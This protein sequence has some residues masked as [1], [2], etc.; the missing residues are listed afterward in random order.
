MCLC[1]LAEEFLL[2]KTCAEFVQHRLYGIKRWHFEHGTEEKCALHIDS[3]FN[4]KTF[5][6]LKKLP[7]QVKMHILS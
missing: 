7:E 4:T 3:L 5:W 6:P 2:R 1:R